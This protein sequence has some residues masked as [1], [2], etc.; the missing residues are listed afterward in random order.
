[1]TQK[2]TPAWLW[3]VLS[4]IVFQIGIIV[5]FELHHRSPQS[6]PDGGSGLD[7]LV[8]SDCNRSI[9]Q[10]IGSSKASKNTKA[11]ANVLRAGSLCHGKAQKQA[12]RVNELKK[13]S[14]QNAASKFQETSLPRVLAIFF[15]Q[16]HKD[17]LNDKN[18]GDNF[19][20]WVSLKNSAEKNRLGYPIPRPTELGYYDLNSKKTRIQQE[21]LAEDHNVDGF[22]YHH[23]WFYDK[24]H[25]GPNLA[26]PLLNMLEDG[27]PN[28]PFFFNW[29]P[30]RWI[31]VWMGK[32]IF[33]TIPTNRNRAIILQDQYWNVTDEQ[34]KDHY[35][36]LSQ[37]FHHHNY[38]RVNNQP[39][40]LTYTFD[41]RA[42]PILSKLR[43]LAIEDGFSGLHLIAGRSAMPDHIYVPPN[44]MTTVL[45][46]QLMRT[47]QTLETIQMDETH[48]N[49]SIF[50]QS[51][52]YPFPL[53][54][55]SKSY[56]VP[57]WCLDKAHSPPFAE[58]HQHPEVVGVITTFDNSPRRPN[59]EASIYNQGPADLVLQKF[60]R[61][62]F[63]SVYY[64]T[65]C[66]EQRASDD[67]F[68][69]INAWNE[70]GESMAMEPSDVYGTRFL[71]A[72]REVKAQVAK[73]GCD[74][75]QVPS[76]SQGGAS[77]PILTADEI[78]AKFIKETGWVYSPETKKEKKRK[79]KVRKGGE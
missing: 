46:Q 1:M 51:M 9:F 37:F 66:L 31:N 21:K 2:S 60:R 4:I 76:E 8:L 39:V 44:N 35:D 64:Q 74:G 18:W 69:A 56:T 67:R 42:I 20:D 26:Q 23:Y 6:H 73:M 75:S 53:E 3:F 24:T 5:V 61:N 32:A 55:V 41:E 40:F 29:C 63:A 36:W 54:Y 7:F 68:V 45:Q 78:R 33:Q 15:P 28:V 16:Y 79:K 72:I 11:F 70:W 43:Q 48:A 13:Q 49:S 19:T 57:K 10:D 52:F 62:L 17:P 38:I 12:E 71:E 59:N 47:M 14:L 77:D 50:N 25:P 58:R 34:I 30:V 27:H 22:I 65:C